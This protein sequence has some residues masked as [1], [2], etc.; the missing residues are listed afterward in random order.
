MLCAKVVTVQKRSC[1]G[2]Q[3]MKGFSNPVHIDMENSNC[4]YVICYVVRDDDWGLIQFYDPLMQIPVHFPQQLKS[5]SQVY[6]SIINF[7]SFHATC[8]LKRQKKKYIYIIL[9]FSIFLFSCVNFRF[10]VIIIGCC[11]TVLLHFLI[12]LNRLSYSTFTECNY[13]N[14]IPSTLTPLRKKSFM[15][16]CSSSLKWKIHLQAHLQITCLA[17]R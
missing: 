2:I 3:F 14:T 10:E 8:L 5:L 7:Q 4:L 16:C 12:S 17:P 15:I 11:L 9:M 13:G 6:A 1:M